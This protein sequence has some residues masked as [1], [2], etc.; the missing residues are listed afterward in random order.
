MFRWSVSSFFSYPAPFYQGG[1]LIF[2]R[3]PAV[4]ERFDDGQRFAAYALFFDNFSPMLESFFDN[5]AHADK[6]T[7]GLSAKINDP[8]GGISEGQEIINE[9]YFVF[10][11]QV[12]FGDDYLIFPLLVKEKMVV[13]SR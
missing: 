5:K 11:G 3:D 1:H 2:Q 7:A 10:W 12:V 8:V 6:V 9:Q 13:E 4:V